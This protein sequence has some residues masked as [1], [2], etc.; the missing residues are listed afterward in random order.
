MIQ[1]GE[2]TR[3][4]EDLLQL[5][6]TDTRTRAREDFSEPREKAGEIFLDFRTEQER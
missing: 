1:P 4:D 2:T 3:T 6:A 5:E